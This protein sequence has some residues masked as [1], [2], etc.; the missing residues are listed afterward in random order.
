M[1]VLVKSRLARRVERRVNDYWLT[2]EQGT[3]PSVGQSE[4]R[5]ADRRR[6]L[7]VSSGSNREDDL[8]AID[9]VL[10][11]VWK[12]DDGNWQRRLRPFLD[13][14]RDEASR[15]FARLVR[16]GCQPDRL[17][18]YFDDATAVTRAVNETKRLRRE[19]DDLLKLTEAAVQA[20]GALSRRRTDFDKYTSAQGLRVQYGEPGPATLTVLC[21]HLEDFAKDH[22]DELRHYLRQ[23]DGRRQLLLT[24][25]TMKLSHGVRDVTGRFHDSDVEN[26]LDCLLA[27]QGRKGRNL[28]TLKR[29]RSRWN[30]RLRPSGSRSGR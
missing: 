23:L 20:V 17:A 9:A 1:P 16:A 11:Q 25:P 26:I 14:L 6:E 19:I 15:R 7:N 22:S 21:M 27:S 5:P 30:A 28:G 10:D 8:R 12:A 4:P 2:L 13:R 18:K 3:A 24:D 29:R